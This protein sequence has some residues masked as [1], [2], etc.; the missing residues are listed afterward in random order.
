MNGNTNIYYSTTNLK[1][2][3]FCK[4]CKF[5]CHIQDYTNFLNRLRYLHNANSY[6][7]LKH[8]YVLILK[9]HIQSLHAHYC[10]LLIVQSLCQQ[11]E[12][13]QLL[14]LLIQMAS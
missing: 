2:D 7:N 6:V 3:K 9:L 11:H 5:F 8:A 1:R 12:P 10:K 14:L 13:P 4:F